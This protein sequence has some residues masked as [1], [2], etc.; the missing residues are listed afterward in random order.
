M[1]S[2]IALGL[3]TLLL[4][5]SLCFAEGAFTLDDCRRLAREK[6]ADVQ[7]A[8]MELE[9]A[10]ETHKAAFTKYFPQVSATAGVLATKDPFNHNQTT[11]MNLPVYNGDPAMLSSAS[12]Y[13]YV[14]S[15]S[16]N[17]SRWAND[18]SFTVVQPLYVGG[19]VVKGNQLASLGE[20]VARSKIT[21]AQRDAEAQTEEKYWMLLSLQEKRRT[22]DAYDTMLASLAVQ[23]E[24]AIAHG[25]TTHNDILKVRLKKG[26][27]RNNRLQLES[28]LRLAARDLRQ[29]LGLSE[30]TSLTLVDSLLTPLD[31]APLASLR[32]GAIERRIETGLLAQ[33]VH[34]EELQT[35]IERGS[36]LP[37]VLVGADASYMKISGLD[38]SSNLTIFGIVSVPISDIWTSSHN[39]ETHR[40]K[41]RQAR[42]QEAETRRKMDLGV[43]KDWDDL[44][45][46]YQ[47]NQ[48]AEETVAQ[49]EEN[50]R[51]ET[52]RHKNG[53]STLADFLDAQAMLQQAEDRRIDARKDYWLAHQAFLRSTG[54]ND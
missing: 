8:R 49:A 16:L 41:T 35:D 43:S 21:L 54:S 19:R 53:I 44:V 50:L 14:P 10:T 48:L 31:P 2:L 15:F 25:I 32:K 4:F 18:L 27:V 33:N 17:G 52:D 1:R 5:S 9:S 3:I 42:L 13:A 29:H 45:R 46:S 38:A 28:G 30:D 24:D 22:L 11:P 39:T 37:S 12:Q 26:E 23:V 40:I 20:E 7:N 34:A 36:M 51:E 6:N 47:S